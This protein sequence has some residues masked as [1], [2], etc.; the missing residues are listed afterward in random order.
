MPRRI[1]RIAAGALIVAALGAPPASARLIDQ[2]PGNSDLMPYTSE[3]GTTVTRTID[4]G[5]DLG[6]ASVGA[7]AVL[8]L[9]AAGAS[10]VS[11]RRRRV[12]VVR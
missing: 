9:T 3:P 10:A 2:R 5:F 11:H 12:D 6:S 1:T 7:A 4:Q 8:L